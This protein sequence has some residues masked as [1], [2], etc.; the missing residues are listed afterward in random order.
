MNGFPAPSEQWTLTQTIPIVG[1]LS[2]DSSSSRS[3]RAGA[4]TGSSIASLRGGLEHQAKENDGHGG[5]HEGGGEEAEE[6]QGDHGGFSF[7][8]AR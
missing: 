7:S 4:R 6:E 3:S 1:M 8:G 2:G 5:E